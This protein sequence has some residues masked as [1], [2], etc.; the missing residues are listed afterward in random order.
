M[1]AEE[2]LKTLN[3]CQ[4]ECTGRECDKCEEAYDAI[5]KIVEKADKY[6]WHD[7]LENPDN[8]PE[9]DHN[10][11]VCTSS[12]WYGIWSRTTFDGEIDIWENEHAMYEDI[13][14]VIAWREIEPFEEVE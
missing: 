3:R 4:C 6:R 2:A 13:D 10:V 14:E 9:Y 7:L 12:N 11:L 8:L 5:Q 1:T